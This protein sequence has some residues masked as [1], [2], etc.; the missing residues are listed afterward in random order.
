MDRRALVSGCVAGFAF[1]ANYTNHAPMIA[2]LRGEFGFD[3]TRAGLLTT[4]IFLTHALMMV[5]GGRLGDR[6]G[7]G[8]VIAAALAWIAAAN[9][10]LAFAG[11]YWQLL[12]W[13]AFAGIGTGACFA[14]GARYIV[15]RFEGRERH[16]A[17]GLFGGSIVLGSGFVLFAVPQLLDAFGWRGACVACAL[18][19]VAAWIWWLTGAPHQRHVVR[20]A[21]G[22]REVAGH[23]ELWLLGVIQMASF[24]L[25][26]VVGSWITVLLKT[27]F[28]MPLKTAGVM[29]SMV[30]LLGILSRPAGRMAGAA[31]AD[32]S[33]GARR[34]VV[35]CGGV[36]GVGVGA[37]DGLDLGCDCGS[38]NGLRIA[39]CRH[40]QSRG[41]AGSRRRRVGDGAGE[42][43]GDR[44]DSG[45]YAGGGIPGRLD[46]P[47]SGQLLGRWAGSRCSPPR[48]RRPFRSGNESDAVVRFVSGGS[49]ATRWGWSSRAAVHFRRDRRAEQRMAAL[50]RARGLQAA[51]PARGVSR[52][53]RRMIDIY[54]ACVKLG[55]IFVP[56]N[57]LYREKEIQHILGRCRAEGGGRDAGMPDGAGVARGPTANPA[58]RPR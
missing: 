6:F 27:S 10:A 55:V 57:I 21:P 41:G 2:V 4:A 22:L 32:T 49:G 39:V 51:R 11:A 46:R 42:Y 25:V 44:D 7:A 13:K 8:R 52:E 3:Q 14:A 5:P 43:G 1:S 50:F 12:F 20:A 26:I 34:H 16:I 48:W 40:I 54:L 30:L 18:V 56:V 53:L 38:G 28:Q 17:Q 47:I 24:G 15:V 33:A 37:V 29:G 45:G 31:H 58:E 19:A 9:F 35:E 23:G 36:R